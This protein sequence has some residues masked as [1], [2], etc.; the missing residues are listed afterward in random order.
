MQETDDAEKQ[1][2]SS[3]SLPVSSFLL[4][5]RVQALLTVVAMMPADSLG[6]ADV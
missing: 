1:T 4:L 3:W 6:D 2:I 5:H